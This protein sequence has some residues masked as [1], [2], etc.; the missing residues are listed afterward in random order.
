MKPATQAKNSRSTQIF[1]VVAALLSVWNLV[2]F[3]FY[4]RHLYELLAGIGFG[5]WAYSSL[6]VGRHRPPEASQRSDF[7]RPASYVSTVALVL[8]VTSFVLRLW[9]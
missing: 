4:G 3:A 8:V 2:N 5:L 6:L 9:P 1:V 7:N